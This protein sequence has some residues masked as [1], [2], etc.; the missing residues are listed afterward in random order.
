MRKEMF[1]VKKILIAFLIFCLTLSGCSAKNNDIESDQSATEDISKPD[2]SSISQETTDTKEDDRPIVV[3]EP[4]F[5]RVDDPV[6]TE[7]IEDSVYSGL[8]DKL[9]SE[10]FIVENVRAV[11]LSDEYIEELTYNS[12]ENIFFGYT[13]SELDQ[14]FGDQKYY[15]TLG[16]DGT[17][18][19]KAFEKYDDSY[20]KMLKNVVIGTGVI[21]VCVAVT[22]ATKGA[23]AGT[24]WNT[25]NYYFALAA[26]DAVTLSKL[27]IPVGALAGAIATAIKEK[28]ETKIPD[29]LKNTLLGATEGYKWGAIVGSIAGFAEG[30]ISKYLEAKAAAKSAAEAAKLIADQLADPNVPLWRKAELR[31]LQ[32]FG[33]EEQVSYLAG[34]IVERGTP[35]ATVPDIVRTVDGVT[36]A[37]EVKYYN[38]SSPQSLETLFRELRREISSRVANLPEGS[39]QRIVLDVTDRG[40]SSELVESVKS[41]IIEKLMDIYPNIPVSIVGL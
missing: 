5:T 28:D 15:F 17:T 6:L 9:N 36:E 22:Y 16:E 18:V 14:Q 35:G 4:S 31:A 25:V 8:V 13:L 40:F 21:T 12:K 19:V 23:A 37:I 34:K 1:S 26:K 2:D 41:A 32:Q 24:A 27:G 3:E 11:Y 33:G 30:A 7:Y 38:L 39:I 10:D 20:E 29:L